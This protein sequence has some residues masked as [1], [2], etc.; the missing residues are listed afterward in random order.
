[1]CSLDLLLPAFFAAAA[2]VVAS[3]ASK[4]RR[5][6]PAGRALRAARLPSS[7]VLVRALGLAE[8]AV[9][10]WCLTAPSRASAVSLGLLYLAFGGFLLVLMRGSGGDATCGCLGAREVPPSLLH[11]ALDLV[12]S[13][14]SVAVAVAP[15]RGALAEAARLPLSGVPFVAG[16]LLIAFLAYLVV[17]YLPGSFWSYRRASGGTA[18]ATPFAIVSRP[19][20]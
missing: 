3:G 4:I 12:A 13:G 17:G 18:P 19:R 1:V 14:A 10:A 15:P 5:P 20:R 6:G 7:S 9:G 2:L 8:V 11:V 16:I